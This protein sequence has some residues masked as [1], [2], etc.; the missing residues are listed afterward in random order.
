MLIGFKQEQDWVLV[1]ANTSTTGI[2]SFAQ[3]ATT[4]QVKADAS[5]TALGG[6]AVDPLIGGLITSRGTNPEASRSKGQM[7]GRSS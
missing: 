7:G 3:L 4:T 1:T 6:P 2:I 5:E